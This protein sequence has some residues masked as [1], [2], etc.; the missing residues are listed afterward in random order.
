MCNPSAYEYQLG[1]AKQNSMREGGAPTAGVKA[2]RGRFAALDKFGWGW[3]NQGDH[4]CK[5]L[6]WIVITFAVKDISEEMSPFKK[7]PNLTTYQRD[8]A[9]FGWREHTHQSSQVPN[10]DNTSP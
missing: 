4:E 5:V 3:P 7:I 1:S 10:I 6:E 2:L 9:T 8:S